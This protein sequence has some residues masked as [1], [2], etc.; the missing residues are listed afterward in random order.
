MM[1]DVV[2]A[3]KYASWLA[4][5]RIVKASGYPRE[6]SAVCCHVLDQSNNRPWELLGEMV[7][8]SELSRCLQCSCWCCGAPEVPAAHRW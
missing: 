1:H 5:S 4:R 7:Q 2:S 8:P 6:M 3:A